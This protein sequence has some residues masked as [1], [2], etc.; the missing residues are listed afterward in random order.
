MTKKSNTKEYFFFNKEDITTYINDE[1]KI[2]R[3]CHKTLLLLFCVVSVPT[4]TSV[5]QNTTCTYGKN[6][7]RQLQKQ[8]SGMFL[9]FQVNFPY[10]F[11][12]RYN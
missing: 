11:G 8:K 9:N 4:D 2:T 12:I 10:T 3:K 6:H 7:C 1:L 5:H